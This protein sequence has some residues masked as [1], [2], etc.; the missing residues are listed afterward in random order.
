MATSATCARAPSRSDVRAPGVE[1]YGGALTAR[2]GWETTA[3][4]RA[5]GTIGDVLGL[6]S[7]VRPRGARRLLALTV[8][9]LFVPTGAAVADTFAKVYKD[10][11]K[12]GAIDPCRFTAKELQT[13]RREVTPD[14]DQYAP[15]FPAA[16]D[17]AIEARANGACKK[18]AAGSGDTAQTPAGR[19]AVLVGDRRWRRPARGAGHSHAAGGR[20]LTDPEPRR[21]DPAAHADPRRG[22]RGG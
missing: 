20:A 7:P 18:K 9:F 17:L 12:D 14:I 22:T 4:T 19:T 21:G 15:D 13:A 16:L 5:D 6:S 8:V 10:Y 1:P 11:A 3:C 2:V